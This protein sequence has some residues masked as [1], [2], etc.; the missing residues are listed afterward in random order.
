MQSSSGASLLS[1]KDR[2]RKNGQN[3][4]KA[5]ASTYRAKSKVAQRNTIIPAVQVVTK[6]HTKA[7]RKRRVT[8]VVKSPL[9]LS[10]KQQRYKKAKN[11]QRFSNDKCK[12]HSAETTGP[13]MG[14]L[15][16]KRA[17]HRVH[18]RQRHQSL[19]EAIKELVKIL[20]PGDSHKSVTKYNVLKK[21][22]DYID[23]LQYKI[24]HLCL[25]L[26]IEQE[27]HD[28]LVSFNAP[29]NIVVGGEP[30]EIPA[31]TPVSPQM[32]EGI[33]KAT[34]DLSINMTRRRAI[35]SDGRMSSPRAHQFRPRK[36]SP[37]MTTK[38]CKAQNTTSGAKDQILHMA[39]NASPTLHAEILSGVTAT[40][41]DSGGEVVDESHLPSETN[42]SM[43][44]VSQPSQLPKPTHSVTCV[45]HHQPPNE[46]S[47]WPRKIALSQSSAASTGREEKET[48]LDH[49]IHANSSLGG[50]Y[51]VTAVTPEPVKEIASSSTVPTQST[52]CQ[53]LHSEHS[54]SARYVP[55]YTL[56]GLSKDIRQPG[57]PVTVSFNSHEPSQASPSE[58]LDAKM[59]TNSLG[60]LSGCADVP[61][62]FRSSVYT[63]KQPVSF[64][65]KIVT[66]ESTIVPSTVVH[67]STSATIYSS[68]NTVTSLGCKNRHP[69]RYIP[70]QPATNLASTSAASKTLLT[71]HRVSSENSSVQS[72][73]STITH[74]IAQKLVVDPNH[75][76]FEDTNSSMELMWKDQNSVMT[77]AAASSYSMRRSWINGFQ[78]FTKVNHPRFRDKWPRLQGREITRL[79]SQTWKELPNDFKKQY[80]CR[81]REW[82]Q[83][84]RCQREA[85][86]Q[87]SK[88]HP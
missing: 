76:K 88:D 47:S 52:P 71:L 3:H 13:K 86:C 70:I 64:P 5:K 61:C 66:C 27:F 2:T 62:I 11:E 15:E 46:D 1:C 35:D 75:L 65:I 67:Q 34:K 77:P 17:V 29:L 73:E 59:M 39:S 38:T 60:R 57:I 49:Y 72:K 85:A 19:N 78:L 23:F 83:W 54:Y 32:L 9:S 14:S 30:L 7:E 42:L 58:T 6:G 44:A 8:L 81:A 79:L 63:Q 24:A 4:G 50:E 82:N 51:A 21:A 43:V 10:K 55:A 48:L 84:H 22:D 87:T 37:E 80:S 26:S 68:P 41:C 69:S 36:K 53:Q 45:S 20:P 16:E 12:F 33:Q 31:V 25:E 28:G 56:S 40:A 18:E 74:T